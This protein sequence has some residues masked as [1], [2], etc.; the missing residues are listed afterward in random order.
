MKC[1]PLPGGGF[2][3]GSGPRRVKCSVPSCTNWATLECDYPVKGRKT[4]TCDAKLCERCTF[5]V[6]GEDVCPPHRT[7]RLKAESGVVG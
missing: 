6:N 3:C 2:V 7:A 5:K 1:T 4:G